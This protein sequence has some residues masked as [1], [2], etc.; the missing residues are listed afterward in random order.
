MVVA[1]LYNVI[2]KILH[3]SVTY[4]DTAHA[5]WADLKER[6]SQGNSI[7]IHQ[8]KREIRSLLLLPRTPKRLAPFF[9]LTL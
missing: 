5:I 1:W 9:F 2:D 6:Y 7:R 3:G 4:A 8:L